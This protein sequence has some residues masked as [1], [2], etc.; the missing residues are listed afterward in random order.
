MHS[1]S[2]L[3]SRLKPLSKNLNLEKTKENHINIFASKTVTVDAALSGFTTVQE[4]LKAVIEQ[5]K[6]VVEKQSQIINDATALKVAAIAS[7]ARAENALAKLQDL[8]GDL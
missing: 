1:E 2:S 6:A 8:T 4:Q 5:D 3:K 7:I